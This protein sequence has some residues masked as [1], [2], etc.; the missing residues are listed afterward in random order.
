MGT[1]DTESP[2][3]GSHAL[4][5]VVLTAVITIGGS[6]VMKKGKNYAK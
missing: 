2:D 1:E 5:Y 4:S 3:T 6:S